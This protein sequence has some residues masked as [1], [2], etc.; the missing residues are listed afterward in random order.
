[1]SN[2]CPSPGTK[3]IRLRDRARRTM[4][5]ALGGLLI[6]ATTLAGTGGVAVAA[7][8]PHVTDVI[9]FTSHVYLTPPQN[10]T[11]RFAIIGDTCQVASNG[12][13]AIPCTFVGGGTVTA[14]GGVARGVVTS[15]NGMIIL[16]ET[17]VFTGPTTSFG[18]GPATKITSA[19]RTT[20]TFTGSFTTAPTANPNVLL[21]WGTFIVSDNG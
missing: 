20:G 10:G 14:T 19:G 2:T 21:D 1:M 7:G 4:G 17:Y 5:P 3:I 12:R 9:T 8:S 13:P 18:S 16:D 11:G 15:S 6:A